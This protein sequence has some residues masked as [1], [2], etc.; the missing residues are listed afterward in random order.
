M[1]T[2]ENAVVEAKRILIA[3]TALLAVNLACNLPNSQ[4]RAQAPGL[5]S[6][7]AAEAV[8]LLQAAGTPSLTSIPSFTE[9][10][11]PTSSITQTSTS[12]APQVGVTAATNCRTGPGMQYEPLYTLQPGQTAKI[13][14][15]DTPDNYWVIKMPNGGTC[16]LWGQYAI[17]S[18][19][20]A[21]LT[22]YAVPPSPT[23]ALP[24]APTN[25]HIRFQCRLNS[26]PF[27]HN[28]VHV[29]ITWQDNASNADG[30][31][32]YRDGTLLTTLNANT[33]GFIDD[34][35]MVALVVAGGPAPAITYAVQAFNAAGKSEKVSKSISCFS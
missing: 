30:Y 29:N 16:W 25:L 35:T 24:A 6:T 14:G 18:G 20:M 2:Q 33:L 27:L 23:P 10:I 5:T 13:V 22:E 21:A 9:T 3:L 12:S 34:T 32:I 19:N 8:L 17:V 1:L 31:Y 11:A 28:D 4:S 7:I 26:S 15:K